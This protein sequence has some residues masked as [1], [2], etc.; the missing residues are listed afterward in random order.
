M[1]EINWNIIILIHRIF[2]QY[3]IW[4]LYL[5]LQ[6]LGKRTSKNDAKIYVDLISEYIVDKNQDLL[7]VE[8]SSIINYYIHKLTQK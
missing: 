7:L 6:K 4:K 1:S 8:A 3:S 2:I 5:L